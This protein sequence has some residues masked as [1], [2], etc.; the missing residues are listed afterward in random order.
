MKKEKI[1]QGKYTSYLDQQSLGETHDMLVKAVPGQSYI[2]EQMHKVN[3][4]E[5]TGM[6]MKK[7]SVG[8]KG[9]FGSQGDA[10]DLEKQVDVSARVMVLNDYKGT[11]ANPRLSNQCIFDLNVSRKKVAIRFGEGTVEYKYLT[12]RHEIYDE[13][14]YDNSLDPTDAMAFTEAVYE[15]QIFYGLDSKIDLEFQRQ[16]H[17]VACGYKDAWKYTRDGMEWD[18]G[19]VANK[20]AKARHYCIYIENTLNFTTKDNTPAPILTG[21]GFQWDQEMSH[22][23]LSASGN[24]N[25]LFMMEQFDRMKPYEEQTR[26]YEE[27][28]VEPSEE[29]LEMQDKARALERK[30]RFLAFR[31]ANK[32]EDLR[33][34]YK[35]ELTKDGK[36]MFTKK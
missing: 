34:V 16:L 10:R 29:F 15:M 35:W 18:N 23:K 20:K 9:G 27:P 14:A 8:G 4:A 2:L 32:L 30:R 12:P 33:M 6:A 7:V 36:S 5:V 24:N 26:F 21:M 22:Q 31:D 19:W 1:I 17:D 11:L 3:T 25:A 28:A 13:F